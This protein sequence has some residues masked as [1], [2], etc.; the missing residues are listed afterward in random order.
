MVYH[1]QMGARVKRKEDPRL[2][3][4]SS[5]YVDDFRLQDTLHA[6]ILRSTYGHARI[7]GIDT[8]KAAAHP[9]V[10]AVYTAQ[11][12]ADLN[13]MPFGQGTAGGAPVETRGVAADQGPH[14]GDAGGGRGAGGRHNPPR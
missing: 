7:R 4:G 2:I 9:G 12:F 10:V 13:P 11:D 1:K 5:T 6:A 8:S 14:V 3:T